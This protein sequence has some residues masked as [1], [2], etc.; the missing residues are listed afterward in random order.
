MATVTFQPA[1]VLLDTPTESLGQP[2]APTASVA[3]PEQAQGGPAPQDTV[4]L[5]GKVSE[6][7]LNGEYNGSQFQ[8]TALYFA[9]QEIFIGQGGPAAGA[10]QAPPAAPAQ[11]QAQAAPQTPGAPQENAQAAAPGTTPPN[12][13]NPAIAAAIAA[14]TQSSTDPATGADAAGG[15]ATTPQQQLQQLDQALQQLG[16]NP[17]S[18]SLFNRMAMLLYAN[19]PA[20]LRVLVEALQGAAQQNG[21]GGANSAATNNAALN[22]ALLQNSGQAP[23]A[24]QDQIQAQPQAAAPT[25][26]QAQPTST[27]GGAA[28]EVVAAQLSF[29]EV[30]GTIQ[31]N[32]AA[33]QA[34]QNNA[35]PD[36]ATTGA[37]TQANSAA[38]QFEKLQLSF[39]EIAV[40]NFGPGTGVNSASGN[41]QALNVTA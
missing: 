7:Q 21:Q 20:A 32:G 24:N 22:Q 33:S 26:N 17:Q 3:N 4:V 10:P 41:G 9:A 18:I 40:Q 16:V 25:Q 31:E 2:S 37:P 5:T 23:P 13:A 11:T 12:A 30:Q 6:T 27:A 28:F 35:T 14:N 8:Q 1:A 36:T 29:T 19:D 34:G 38:V 39:T 15:T